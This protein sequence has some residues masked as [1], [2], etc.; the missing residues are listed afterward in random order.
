MQAPAENSRPD[1]GVEA[2]GNRLLWLAA[3]AFVVMILAWTVFFYVA[4]RH[5]VETVPVG[6]NGGRR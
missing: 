1:R 6:T 5:P 4:H 3:G 2:A